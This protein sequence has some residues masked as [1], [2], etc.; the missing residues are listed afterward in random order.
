MS[1]KIEA[2]YQYAVML[3]TFLDSLLKFNNNTYE[4][5]LIRMGEN[6][7]NTVN[8]V[9]ISNKPKLTTDKGSICLGGRWQ[10]GRT[11]ELFDGNITY[12][13]FMSPNLKSTYVPVCNRNPQT[14]LDNQTC[15]YWSWKD[16]RTRQTAEMSNWRTTGTVPP[17]W[18]CWYEP[19]QQC[20]SEKCLESED[21]AKDCPKNNKWVKSGWGYR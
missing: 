10:S 8:T 5:K 19:A 14:L 6:A 15:N 12:V 4:I 9:N 2:N 20:V 18:D 16:E 7:N 17:A 11:D 21:P 3:N 1:S 13:D